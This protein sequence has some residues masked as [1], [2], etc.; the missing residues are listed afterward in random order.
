MAEFEERRKLG[1]GQFMT[2]AEIE[3]RNSVLVA[4]LVRTF[5][6]VDVLTGPFSHVAINHRFGGTFRQNVCPFKV[7]LDGLAFPTPNLDDLP[8]PKDIA[9]I[10]LYSG[11]ATIPLRYK[12]TGG[13]WCGV[14]LVWT[15]GGS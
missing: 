6:S 8:S 9:G 14:I 1:F 5:L 15:K 13:A 11:A 7:F 2:Q 3:K 10:E 4:D 12:T